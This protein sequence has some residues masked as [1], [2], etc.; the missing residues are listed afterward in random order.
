L[1]R[2]K[3]HGALEDAPY[4]K[5]NTKI[6]RIFHK[7]KYILRGIHRQQ[8]DLVTLLLVCEG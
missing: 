2:K 7:L 1:L 8:G 3:L 4:M 5:G 6:T